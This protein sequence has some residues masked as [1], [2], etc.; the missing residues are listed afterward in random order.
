MFASGSTAP[1][2]ADGAG[3][4]LGA[5]VFDA[6]GVESAG[7][8]SGRTGRLRLFEGSLALPIAGCLTQGARGT[9]CR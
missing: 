2:A 8:G 1:L 7:G 3:V 6:G 9:R 4:A 5:D